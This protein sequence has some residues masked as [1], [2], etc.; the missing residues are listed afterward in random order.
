MTL[1]QSKHYDI[2]HA[3]NKLILGIVVFGLTKQF[4]PMFKRSNDWLMI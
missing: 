2:R 3:D 1:F 4:R